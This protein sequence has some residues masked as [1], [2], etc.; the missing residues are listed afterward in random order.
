MKSKTVLIVFLVVVAAVVVWLL[1]RPSRNSMS[2]SGSQSVQL[3][4]VLPLTGEVAS[5]GTGSRE[6]IEFAVEQANHAQ[7]KY[8]FEVI[9][10]D[11]KGDPKTAVNALQKLLTTDKPTAVIGENTSSS[12]LAMVPVIDAAKVVLVSPSA[13]APSLAGKSRY[14]YRVFPSDSEEGDFICGVIKERVPNARVCVAYVN[15]DYGVGL[16]DVFVSRAKE[17]GVAILDTFGY[18][19]GA[20][21]FRPILAKL[22]ALEPNTVYIPSYYQDGAAFL[23]QAR[24]LGIS[25]SFWGATAD[26]D[27]QFLAIAGQAAE[28]FHYPVAAAYDAK[29]SDAHVKEFVS[30]FQASRGK[31][32]GLLAALGYDSAKLILDGVLAKGATSEGIREFIAAQKSYLG[33]TGLMTF[34]EQGE[35][36]KPIRLRMVKDG[37]FV[38]AP[39]P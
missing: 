26:E 11:S 16:K 19:K 17:R 2:S 8:R 34:D 37:K 36:H 32:P 13:S 18:E 38:D 21:D 28:D 7:T 6:G 5:Y 29:S 33:V 31:E 25:A 10:E 22:K 24:E 4:A 12:T 1:Q 20:T 3:G 14:F 35:V 27:P 15:N 30:G 9:F 23:K 39:T